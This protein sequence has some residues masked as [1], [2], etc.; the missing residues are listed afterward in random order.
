MPARITLDLDGPASPHPIQVHGAA[1]A[2]LEARAARHSA[3]HKPFAAAPPQ[4]VDDGTSWRLGWLPDTIPHLVDV[5]DVTFGR[6][7]YR[8]RHLE[9]EATPF[10]ALADAAPAHRAELTMT[11]PTYFRH[12]GH[13]HPLPDPAMI[14]DSAVRRW[15]QHAALHVPDDLH[16]E[17]RAAVHLA[18]MTGQ[19]QTVTMIGDNTHTGF[20]GHIHL[21]VDRGT[22]Q[23]ALSL[24]ASLLRF[25]AIAGVGAQ[26][27]H[28]FGAIDLLVLH[29]HPTRTDPPRSPR[30]RRGPRSDIPAAQTPSPPFGSPS[31]DRD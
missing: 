19:T 17:L 26:T 5:T 22:S 9:V 8:V 21:G 2:L 6:A 18:G 4:T 27:T 24:F 20:V 30:R 14:I 25:I 13:E 12:S 3:Q 23:P 11:S 1:C 31:E 28:G 29:G 7:T 16:T 15:N 10:T